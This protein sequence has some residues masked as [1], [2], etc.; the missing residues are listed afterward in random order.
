MKNKIFVKIHLVML[1][2][3]LCWVCASCGYR[4]TGGGELPG[5]IKSIC[6]DLFENRTSET[7]LENVISND[8]NYEVTR[9]G[10][11]SLKDR[12]SADAVLSG[13]IRSMAVDAISHKGKSSIERRVKITVDLQLTGSDGS[14]LWVGRNISENEDYDVMDDK[15]GTEQ[16][17]SDA[18][19]ELSK[20]LSEKI[21]NSMGDDF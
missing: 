18:V 1:A 16:N 8:L 14:V 2:I 11:V 17:R 4:F 5:G 6:I 9:N 3:V 20:R 12:D 15:H 7:G 21:Y 10:R 19:E 13:V